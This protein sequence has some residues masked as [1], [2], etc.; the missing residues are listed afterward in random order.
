MII[1]SH[2]Y[3]VSRAGLNEDG[4]W[5]L[6][7]KDNTN[8]ILIDKSDKERIKIY[9]GKRIDD[10]LTEKGINYTYCGMKDFERKVITTISS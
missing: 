10:L 9:S 6:R 8:W 1:E 3:E 4:F 2:F 7:D 5:K